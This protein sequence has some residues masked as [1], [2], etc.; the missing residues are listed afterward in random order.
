MRPDNLDKLL[1]QLV[2]AALIWAVVTFLT[3]VMGSLIW[4]ATGR[5]E[6]DHTGPVPA[7]VT[8]LSGTLYIVPFGVRP[9]SI[10]GPV[11][12][13]SGVANTTPLKA[14]GGSIVSCQ[15][16]QD[17]N[18]KTGPSLGTIKAFFAFVTAWQ[19]YVPEIIFTL[20]LLTFPAVPLWKYYVGPWYKGRKSRKTMKINADFKRKEMGVL[21]AQDRITDVEYR[22]ALQRIKDMDGWEEAAA[23]VR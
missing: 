8:Q 21:Y 3:V 23:E 12:D 11:A 5:Q 17:W 19:F 2:P 15:E 13:G 1:D 10:C 4:D 20:I 6:S 7:G 18:V 16:R 9:G 14:V 22:D